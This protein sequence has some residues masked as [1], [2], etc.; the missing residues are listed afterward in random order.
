MTAEY[1]TYGKT[2]YIR[3]TD[4]KI[5]YGIQYSNYRTTRYHHFHTI[6]LSKRL[7]KDT[8]IETTQVELTIVIFLFYFYGLPSANLEVQLMQ[9]KH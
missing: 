5:T 2:I 4:N 6:L 8:D 9:L 7:L 1:A 3:Y